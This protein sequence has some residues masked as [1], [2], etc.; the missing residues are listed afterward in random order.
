MT[1]SEQILGQKFLKEIG[2][3]DVELILGILKQ[4]GNDI[5]INKWMS[6]KVVATEVRKAPKAKVAVPS[7]KNPTDREMNL[8]WDFDDG[9]KFD[10]DGNPF[11]EEDDLENNEGDDLTAFIVTSKGQ[12]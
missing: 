10:E 2:A 11:D 12:V 1:T 5:L 4:Y 8:F 3:E 9:W 7:Y 6:V